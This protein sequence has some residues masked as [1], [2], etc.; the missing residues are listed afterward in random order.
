MSQIAGK[1][2]SDTGY[3]LMGKFENRFISFLR[4]RV[5]PKA[6]AKRMSLMLIPYRP[7]HAHVSI[8]V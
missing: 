2:I 3:G 8:I 4:H 6:I 1:P 7:N 5:N